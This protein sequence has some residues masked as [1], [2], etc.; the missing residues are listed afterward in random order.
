MNE[1]GHDV[2]QTMPGRHLTW[3]KVRLTLPGLMN[4]QP[5]KCGCHKNTGLTEKGQEMEMCLPF[6]HSKDHTL[7]STCERSA[8]A[9]GSRDLTVKWPR[10]LWKHP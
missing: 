8:E 6:P 1:N 9:V 10:E 5:L 2:D 4:H 3:G 7:H